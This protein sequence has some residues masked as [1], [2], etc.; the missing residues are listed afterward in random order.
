M[1]TDNRKI[2]KCFLEQKYENY[3]KQK[4]LLG[5]PKG[6]KVYTKEYCRCKNKYMQVHSHHYYCTDRC[7]KVARKLDYKIYLFKRKNN[8]QGK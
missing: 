6:E 4:E 8:L 5:M 2:I 7:K 3:L 1:I